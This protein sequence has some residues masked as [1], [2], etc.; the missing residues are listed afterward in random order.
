VI[1]LLE[2][3][4]YCRTFNCLPEPGGLFQQDHYLMEGMAMVV[5]A[6]REREEMEAKK[7]K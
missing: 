4:A 2:I 5:D 6:T 7:K 1:R 3:T